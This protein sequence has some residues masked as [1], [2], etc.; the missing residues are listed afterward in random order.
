MA[1]PHTSP[2]GRID[3]Q[4]VAGARFSLIDDGLE[5]AVVAHLAQTGELPC[6]SE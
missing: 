4:S 5:H 3:G 1:A 6:N 2:A